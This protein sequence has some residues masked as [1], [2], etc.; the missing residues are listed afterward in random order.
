MLEKALV[1]SHNTLPP[2]SHKDKS[3]VY[4]GM[5]AVI[6]VSWLYLLNMVGQHS[7][8]DMTMMGMPQI[9]ADSRTLY[10]FLTL[11]LM[12]SV[13][14][15]AM[16]L[17]SI[18]PATM[19]FT[20]FN[21]RK[22]AQAQP[23]IGTYIFAIG[24]LLAWSAC[25]LLFA[26]AQS[27]LSAAGMLGHAMK[28]NSLLLS[29]SI[30]LLAGIYQWTPLKEVCLKHCRSPLGFFIERWREGHWGAVSMGWRYGLFCVG[31]CWALMAIMFA[32]GTMNILWMAV[33]AIFVLCEKIFPAGVLVRNVAGILLTG[34]GGY[35]LISM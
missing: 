26:L 30:L 16:M 4:I 17:P 29:G 31:C 28:T 7:R 33:L 14:M 11:F 22:K 35:L 9:A 23:Y 34:W 25:S 12:W 20:A 2:L 32:V 1:N 5:V 10:H 24:Y 15:T 19:V 13:M 21:R 27:G 18:L 6:L 3:V 8:M